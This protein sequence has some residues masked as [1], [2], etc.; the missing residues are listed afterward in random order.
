MKKLKHQSIKF[1]NYE[2]TPNDRKGHYSKIIK[3]TEEYKPIKN[4]PEILVDYEQ[5]KR[6]GHQFIRV[7]VTEKR[8]SKDNEKFLSIKWMEIFMQNN[9]EDRFEL[10]SDR[11]LLEVF[12]GDCDDDYFRCTDDFIKQSN[13]TFYYNREIILGKDGKEIKE[14]KFHLYVHEI[15]TGDDNLCF[16]PDIKNIKTMEKND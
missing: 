5:N 15:K 6:T 13:K 2:W 12:D 3:K 9:K 14:L 8:K 4:I 1:E 11:I 10:K 7:I 16:D